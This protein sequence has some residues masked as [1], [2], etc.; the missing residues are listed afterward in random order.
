MS[1]SP[2]HTLPRAPNLVLQPAGWPQPKGYAN[3]IK[4]RGDLLFIGGMTSF[5]LNFGEDYVTERV[6]VED[7]RVR[8]P[9][10]PGLARWV[11]WERLP[12]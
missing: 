4:A 8:L 3:G 2:T 9:T 11:D 10:T 6:R 12:R 7:G 5:F 1:N